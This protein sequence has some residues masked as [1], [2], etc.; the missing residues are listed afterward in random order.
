M[1]PSPVRR[2]GQVTVRDYACEYRG[3]IGSWF[4]DLGKP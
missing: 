1:T 2:I 4:T 3:I